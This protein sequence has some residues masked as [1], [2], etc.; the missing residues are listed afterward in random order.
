MGAPSDHVRKV[1]RRFDRSEVNKR[2]LVGCC[3]LH[4]AGG[5]GRVRRVW[6]QPEFPSKCSIEKLERLDAENKVLSSL[7][8]WG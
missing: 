3:L 2:F 5:L 6:L 4:G 1:I 8:S 7:N